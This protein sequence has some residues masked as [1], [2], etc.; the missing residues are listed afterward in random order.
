MGENQKELLE[1]LKE[2][3]VPATGCT[4]PIAVAY[5]VATAKEQ[6]KG[7]LESIHVQVDSNIYKNGLRVTIPGTTEKGLMA[8]AAFG[9]IAGDAKRRLRVIES[10]TDEDITEAKRLIKQKKVELSLKKDSTG[11]DI[12]VT[13]LTDRE[14]VKVNI[15]DNHLNIVN[16]EKTDLNSQFKPLK[17]KEQKINSSNHQ[18]QK[19][20]LE[21][22]L[23]FS[24]ETPLPELI[25]LEDGIKMNM[26]IARKGLTIKSGVGTKLTEMIHEGIISD[27]IVTRAQVLCAAASEA[28]MSGSRLPVMS[29]AGSGNHGIMVFLASFA[30]A[31]KR[32]LSKEK[33]IRSLT[34]SNL[35]TFF[36]KSYTGV[37]SA[38]CGCGVAAGIGASAGIAYLLGG[39]KKQILGSLYNMVGSISGMICDGAKNGCAYK[40]ALA[41]GWAVQSAL[42]ALKGAIINNTDG[43]ID[44]DFKQL[45]K[46]LGYLCDPGIIAT[47][48]AILDVILNKGG[49]YS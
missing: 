29:T 26:K 9:F 40:L 39:N 48:Q 34:L 3:I 7:N 35:I 38:M 1:L 44:P 49:Y 19:Y 20:T 18:I 43:I 5:A 4:E 46:N 23:Q 32:N 42:L 21:D 14:K 8:A 47:D 11:L 28:R 17:R 12:E 10:I 36:I 22:F 31:E 2:R 25:F 30:V 33:L 13:L 45:F 27:N 16:I 6:I 37:L 24:N 41:S 15:L